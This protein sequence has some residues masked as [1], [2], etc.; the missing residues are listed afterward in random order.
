MKSV[1]HPVILWF[2]LPALAMAADPP[3]HDQLAFF[4]ESVRPLLVKHCY[5]CH[6][7]EAEKVKGGLLLDTKEGWMAGGDSGEAILPG[8]PEESLVLE[9]VRYS[10]P[11]LQM[12]PKYRLS[13]E[14]VGILSEWIA[15]GAPDPRS[16]EAV[17]KVSS[18]DWEKGKAHW[19]LRFHS[20][21]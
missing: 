10:D 14:E 11:D 3:T 21:L 15:M 20:G 1:F 7:T 9:T 18:I 12:P 6:S 5:E 19:A 17:K 16:G 2:G 8:K 13:E 4:E